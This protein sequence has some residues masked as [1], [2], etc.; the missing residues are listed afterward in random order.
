[1]HYKLFVPG[2]VTGST[3]NAFSTLLGL[4][5]ANVAGNRARLRKLV[6][7]GSGAAPQDV[8]VALKLQRTDNTADGTF[9]RRQHDLRRQGGPQRDRLQPGGDR[10]Q[11]LGRA[12]ELPGRPAGRRRAEQPRHAGDRVGA[13]RGPPIWPQPDPRP[14]GRARLGHGHQ[15]G[16]HG[17]VGRILT[18]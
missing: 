6:I 14:A 10:Q 17:R 2:L 5:M 15:P 13:G 9:D 12:D 8:Q 7:A 11:L 18:E 1:M 4:K 3:A 16:R